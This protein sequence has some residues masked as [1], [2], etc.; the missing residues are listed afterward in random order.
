MG[1]PKKISSKSNGD[2]L[3]DDINEYERQQE[4]NIQQNNRKLQKL[5]IRR[6]MQ[7]MR[8][9]KENDDQYRLTE[10]ER[11]QAEFDDVP[12][13]AKINTVRK[14]SLERQCTL[15]TEHFSF[16]PYKLMKQLRIFNSGDNHILRL[17]MIMHGFALRVILFTHEHVEDVGS[18]EAILVKVKKAGEYGK[19]MTTMAVL[20]TILGMSGNYVTQQGSS[21]LRMI[22]PGG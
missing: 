4:L 20:F 9:T 5:G 17:V 11:V 2:P 13:D 12:F 14:A 21:D 10:V 16:L 1:R 22:T 6:T 3:G 7:P 8:R 19:N 15:N 18:F